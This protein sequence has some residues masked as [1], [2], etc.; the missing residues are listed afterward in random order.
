MGGGG[1][2]LR[3]L[4]IDISVFVKTLFKDKDVARNITAQKQAV[5]ASQEE[6]RRRLRR[7]GREEEDAEREDVPD[8]RDGH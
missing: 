3:R 2:I 5:H 1:G 4:E 8:M 6:R 7:I